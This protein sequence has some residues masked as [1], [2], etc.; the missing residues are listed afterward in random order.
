[1]TPEFELDRTDYHLR[2]MIERMQR[3]GRSEA[4]IEKAVLSAA[5]SKPRCKAGRSTR[6]P[7]RRS[8][9]DGNRSA[10]MS[11]PSPT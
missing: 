9:L 1:M 10:T 6:Q 11:H 7:S 3:D 2:L 8:A 5:G 4:A